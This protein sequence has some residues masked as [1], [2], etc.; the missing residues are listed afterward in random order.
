MLEAA[1]SGQKLSKAAYARALTPLREALLDAQF[2]LSQKPH[3]AVLLLLAGIDGGGRSE[4]ANALNAWMD[5]RHIRTVAFAKPDCEDAA[6]P[7]AWRYWR[8]MPARGRI[9]I[10]TGAWYADA[11]R[12]EA[13]GS[14]A[15]FDDALHAI[16]ERETML[17]HDGVL[18]L[19][20][21][22]HLSE[23]AAARR[24]DALRKDRWRLERL[25][26]TRRNIA[27]YFERRDVWEH[28]LHTTS[29]TA[30]PWFVVDG[31]DPQH[32]EI[33]IGKLMLKALQRAARPPAGEAR[34]PARRTAKADV[35]ARTGALTAIDLSR[36]LPEQEYAEALSMWQQRLARHTRRKRFGKHSLVLAFEGADA[37]GKGGAIRRVTGALDARQYVNVPISAPSEEEAQYPWLWRFWQHVPGAGG[38]TIFD[39]TWYG[40]VL[41]E[42][43]EGLCSVADWQR[44]YAEIRQ[45]E[46][47]L[48]N[49]GAVICK[50]W[51]QV[52]R[53]EQLARFRARE[54]TPFKRFKITPEDWRNRRRWYDYQQAVADMLERTSTPA[55]QWSPIGADDK[56]HARI[57]VL[58]TI[59]QRLDEVL[60]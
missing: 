10:F 30:A 39:R 8:A 34:A 15:Q 35:D 58:K 9:G 45:F 13:H 42:R 17:A 53:D 29:T 27:T 51:L 56:R 7:P 21:W 60:G 33:A 14:A 22:I 49:A 31:A 18:L 48:A 47:D 59:V 11:A 3:A 32:R 16:R 26:H 46:A 52:S 44:A 4:T 1:E 50:F 36:S 54:K 5:P 43:V 2:T 6:H 40:R 28:L 55:A 38:I 57:E 37:A 20:V 41:V 12:T 25:S 23:R 19:K 24:L